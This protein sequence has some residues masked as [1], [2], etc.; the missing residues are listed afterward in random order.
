MK[1]EIKHRWNGEVLFSFE[2]DKI[3]IAL[4][5]AVKMGAYL[6]GADLRGADLKGADLEGAY[7]EGADLEGADLRGAK[8]LDTARL[9]T[10]ET[11]GEYIREVMPALCIGGGKTLDEVASAWDCHTWDNCP[12]QVA[13]GINSPDKGPALWRHRIRQFVKL[14]DAGLLPKPVTAPRDRVAPAA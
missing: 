14:F 2:T 9:D 12:M 6:E 8:F 1:L 5:A 10:G 4:E 3:K 11:L 7:L 13:F